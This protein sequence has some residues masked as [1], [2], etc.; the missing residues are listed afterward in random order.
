MP[1]TDE[2]LEIDTDTYFT[3]DLDFP[4]RPAWNHNMSP[5]E[6]EGREHRY[7]TVSCL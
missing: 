7:F 6:L 3:P 5:A 1:V 2:D 4:V